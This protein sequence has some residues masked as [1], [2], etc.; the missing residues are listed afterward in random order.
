LLQLARL[1]L[2]EPRDFGDFRT[3]TVTKPG[4]AKRLAQNTYTAP[5]DAALCYCLSARI[6]LHIEFHGELSNGL[7]NWEERK[8]GLRTADTQDEQ[9]V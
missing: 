6:Y 3:N 8:F 9:E 7:L 2:Q 5:V 1:L 4:M